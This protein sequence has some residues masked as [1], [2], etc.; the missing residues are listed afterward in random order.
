MPYATP[1]SN[2][3]TITIAVWALAIIEAMA[4]GAALFSR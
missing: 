4:I 3:R 1:S 2:R